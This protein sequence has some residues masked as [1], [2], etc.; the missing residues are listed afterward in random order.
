[1]S[2]KK[3][4]PTL[5]QRNAFREFR[6]AV[7]ITK[8]ECTLMLSYLCGHKT[9]TSVDTRADFV[10]TLQ[11]KWWDK[12]VTST[13]LPGCVGVVRNL[14]CVVAK[15]V[16]LGSEDATHFQAQVVWG[17]GNGRTIDKAVFA[18]LRLIPD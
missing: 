16:A 8:K 2:I 7:P 5:E 10:R 11:A 12:K 14:V 6:L 18:E 17:E 3:N 1:M 13:S 9:R 15:P 4:L